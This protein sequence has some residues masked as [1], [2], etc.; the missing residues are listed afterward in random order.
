MPGFGTSREVTYV[1][2]Y[3]I[4]WLAPHVAFPL[5]SANLNPKTVFVKISTQIPQSCLK[6]EVRGLL[7]RLK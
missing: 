7:E 5:A 3:R 1:E 4:T 2:C 6:K